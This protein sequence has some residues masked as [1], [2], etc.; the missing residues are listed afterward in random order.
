VAAAA[1]ARDIWAGARG[2][3]HPAS[4]RP[5]GRDRLHVG[6]DGAS[7]G[8]VGG[9]VGEAS[10]LSARAERRRRRRAAS[11]SA[12]RTASDFDL[13]RLGERAGRLTPEQQRSVDDALEVVL[14]L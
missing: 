12:V 11:T 4:R 3:R 10:D 5:V 1:R 9:I 13:D 8:R 7:L 14:G 6:Q 2:R